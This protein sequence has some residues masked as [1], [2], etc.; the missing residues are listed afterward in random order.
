[1]FSLYCVA[2]RVK[3]F[4]T[5]QLLQNKETICNDTRNRKKRKCK[6]KFRGLHIGVSILL[7]YYVATRRYIYVFL[8]RLN[9]GKKWCWRMIFLK[10]R[11]KRRQWSLCARRTCLVLSRYINSPRRSNL[12][13]TRLGNVYSIRHVPT[14]LTK[15]LLRE[16]I[17]LLL[18]FNVLHNHVTYVLTDLCV[19]LHK[20]GR[21]HQP[22]Y[23]G[24]E[25]CER[26]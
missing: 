25:W 24:K 2:N 3:R 21:W 12:F 14:Y 23:S 20:S 19:A 1:M 18:S 4:R 10:I 17:Y 5:A 9:W 22:H 13:F 7:T 15:Y 26:G 6:K 16:S 11:D 8:E